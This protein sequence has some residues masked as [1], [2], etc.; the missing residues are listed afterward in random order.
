MGV[1]LM[2]GRFSVDG[3]F[4]LLSADYHRNGIGGEGYYLG[5]FEAP[6]DNGPG[7]GA[8][9]SFFIVVFPDM[10][11]GRPDFDSRWERVA[12]IRVSDVASGNVFMVPAAGR[13]GTGN[14]ALRAADYY[15]EAAKALVR[16]VEESS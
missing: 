6:D 12:A 11:G 14:A 5:V 1:E 3:D 10:R 2:A 4:T 15:Q 16:L 8:R 13:P 7:P 9:C